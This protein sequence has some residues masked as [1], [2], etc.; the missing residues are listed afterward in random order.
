MKRT[1]SAA[2][3]GA[4]ALSLIAVQPLEAATATSSIAVSTLVANACTISASPLTINYDTLSA[5]ATDTTTSLSVACTLGD[6]AIITLGQGSNPAAGSTE[7]APLRRAQ[8]IASPTSLL[9][10]F[11]Y[12]NSGRTT[13]WGNTAGTGLS[14]TGTGL[15]TSTTVYAR[16]PAGQNVIAGAYTD[17]ITATITY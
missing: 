13:V 4:A 8:N 7:A 3:A 11:L 15:T 16:M 17:S 14:Y 9:S 12:Q 2:L 6:A 1:L 10:Y 5:S